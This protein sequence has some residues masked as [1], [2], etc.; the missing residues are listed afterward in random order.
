M[1]KQEAIA[2]VVTELFDQQVKFLQRLVQTKSANPF[3]PGTASSDAPVEE[4]VA[5]IIR[6]ELQD[7][8][9]P[10]AIHGVSYQRP[11]VLCTLPGLGKKTLLLTTHMDTVEPSNGY[12]RDPWS[13]HIQ[14]GRLYGL[15][16]A[17]AKA[18]IAAFIYAAHALR[19]ADIQLFGTLILAF[20]VDE[21]TGACSPYGTRFLLEK[22]LLHADAVIVGEPGDDK[23]AIGHRG[24]YRFRLLTL[25][26]AAHVGLKAWEQ[27][28]IG[29]NAVLDMARVALALF[30]RSLPAVHSRSFPSRK[31]VLTFPT[32]LQGGRSVNMVPDS[33]EAYGDVRLLP[34]LSV[35][36][37][38]QIIEEE[39]QRLAITK[40]SLDDLVSIPAVEIDPAS[41][42]VQVLARAAQ[43]VTGAAPRIEGAGPACDGWMFIMRGIPA[44]CGYG[45]ACG[46]VHGADEWVDLESLHAVTQV[47][48]HAIVDYFNNNG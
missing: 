38:K 21:E 43:T 18:Q 1:P 37:I 10:V 20:V 41:E 33:C 11:N 26:E 24:L 47:Y 39:L 32:L 15:G 14:D 46:G 19:R 23:I 5:A 4:A 48:A 2:T 45:S 13:A 22:G 44:I 27:G 8:G 7:L 3:T 31:S 9:F 16:A 12:T 30:E 25:G 36:D 34:G 17:D 35:D 29:H 42:I 28:T 40:Y 6:Q